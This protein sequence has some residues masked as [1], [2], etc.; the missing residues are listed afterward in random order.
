MS[1]E[2][3]TVKEVRRIIEVTSNL[4]ETLILALQSVIGY[5]QKY[6]IPLPKNIPYLIT[7][8]KRLM[9]ELNQKTESLQADNSQRV[10]STKAED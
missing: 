6:H 2:Q 1:D 8:A 7:E 9:K 4:L 3:I 5:S 10:D